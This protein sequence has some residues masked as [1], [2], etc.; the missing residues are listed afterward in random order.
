MTKGCGPK[1]LPPANKSGA[2][3]EQAGQMLK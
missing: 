3:P 2:G 1:D